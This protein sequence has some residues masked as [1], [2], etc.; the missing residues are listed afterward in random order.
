M[1][2]ESTIQPFTPGGFNRPRPPEEALLSLRFSRLWQ[3]IMLYFRAVKRLS[4][5]GILIL[6]QML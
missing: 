4:P 5:A 1:L 2:R 3:W 6:P